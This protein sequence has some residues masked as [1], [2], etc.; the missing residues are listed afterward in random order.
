MLLHPRCPCSRASLGEL[1]RIL[2]RVGR[3]VSVHLLFWTP[4]RSTPDWEHTDLWRSAKALPGASA[5]A[6]PA[7]REAALFGARTSGHTALY[8]PAGRLLFRG[9]ITAGRGHA[10]DNAGSAAIL[11]LLDRGVAE[12]RATSVFGCP[13]YAMETR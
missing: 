9:G 10:G 8:D 7:G 4:E 6:D 12:R 11:A 5:S 2:A 3:R 13:L 1:N